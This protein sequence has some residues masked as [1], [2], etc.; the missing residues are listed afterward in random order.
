MRL[1]QAYTLL[2]QGHLDQAAD[3]CEQLI[4]NHPDDHRSL[5]LMSAILLRQG[6]KSRASS[7]LL[8][9]AALQTDDADAQLKIVNALRNM[10][11]LSEAGQLLNQLDGQLD[12]NNPKVAVARARIA[13]QSG[14]YSE[15]LAGFENAVQRWPAQAEPV[16]ALARSCLRMG[17]LDR[18]EQVLLQAHFRWPENPEIRRLQ[19][20]LELDSGNPQAALGHLRENTATT[21]A[22]SQARRLS[23][24]LELLYGDAEPGS[25]SNEDY[26]DESFAWAR[27]QS[28]AITWFG[29]N[30]GLLNWTLGQIPS[31]LP[32]A[33]PIVECGVYHG[34]SL[35]LIAAG[36]QR[37]IH[38]FDSFQGLPEDWKPGEPAG[39]YSTEGRLPACAAHVQLHQGWF[40]DSLPGFAAKLTEPIALLH[41]DCDLYSSTRT[42]LGNLGPKLTTGSLL[43]FDDFLSYAGYEQY[44]F[45]AAQEYFASTHQQFELV[46]AVL[47]GRAVAYRLTRP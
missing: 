13:W 44:E 38:G 4:R 21:E 10:N 5:T 35:N 9:A 37:P 20:V 34:F 22:G 41:V 1:S 26:L 36:T 12:G 47:L 23:A 19:A 29:T 2:Q 27:S 42:V 7:L 28:K 17:K 43:V 6:E 11:A 25:V 46:G 31:N 18:A 40:E 39:S 15:A 32:V 3:L 14:F 8:Q 24:A 45:R 30:T 16:F 33:S